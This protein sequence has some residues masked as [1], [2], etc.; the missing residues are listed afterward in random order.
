MN[1]AITIAI[2]AAT[3]FL[4]TACLD[5]GESD[6]GLDQIRPGDEELLD[7]D[8]LREAA[9]AAAHHPDYVLTPAGL[10]HRSC[11]HDVGRGATIEADDWIKGADGVRFQLPACEFPHFSNARTSSEEP[12]PPDVNGWVVDG[13]R[14][15]SN[16]IKTMQATWTVPP[17]P[18]N[19]ADQVIYF[20]PGIEPESKDRILQ[21]VL[22]WGYS[23]NWWEISSWSCGSTCP[24]STPEYVN[25]GDTIVGT[26]T[27]SSCTGAGACSWQIKTTEV[28]SASTTLNWNAG[29]SY[30]WAFLAL[31]AYYVDR[32]NKYPDASA[33]TFS[34]ISVKKG[35][36][37]SATGAWSIHNARVSPECGRRGSSSGAGNVKLMWNN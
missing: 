13:Y 33:L 19:R 12:P 29:Q 37:S 24:H 9:E 14:H 10:Y 31:E 1:T 26:I 36:G 17:W 21:P 16:W 8:Q 27:G 18:T 4:A 7:P 11:V 6:G 22:Q 25:I 30:H 5:E 2:A 34:S 15:T 35:D 28:G 23:G 32:C 3:A 20:F